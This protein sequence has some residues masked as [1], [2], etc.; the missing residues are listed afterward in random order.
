MM[1]SCHGAAMPGGFDLVQ[2]TD[3]DEIP[4]EATASLKGATYRKD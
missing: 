1:S 3:M 2:A 4:T